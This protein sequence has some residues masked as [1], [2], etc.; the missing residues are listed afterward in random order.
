MKTRTGGTRAGETHRAPMRAWVPIAQSVLAVV[1]VFAFAASAAPSATA[2][3]RPAPQ[4]HSAKLTGFA[5]PARQ[6]RARPRVPGKSSR[7][8][9]RNWGGYITYLS[10]EL[11]DFDSVQATWVQP[12]VTCPKPRAW[13]VFWVGLDGWWNDTV[14]QGGTS[15]ECVGGVP[16]YESWWEMYPTNAITTVFAISPGDRISASVT[17]MTSTS[18]F[19]IAVSD[20]TSGQS[21]TMDEQCAAD[22]S[23][24]RNSADVIA[25]DVGK[26]GSGS[27]FPLADYKTMK[28][29]DSEVADVNNDSGPLADPNWLN[30]PVTEASG[31]TT[32]AKIS[33]L[34]M[35]GN[36]FAATWEHD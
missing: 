17:Y 26:S 24:A 23:C 30:A 6:T 34:N 19:V 14:E 1:T 22:L 21:F 28:F 5:G 15:A 20:L 9:S 2:V 29:T 12:V 33:A 36:G 10:S 35:K 4:A 8:T 27:F 16:E 13:T 18:T 3:S 7:F 31:A 11:T 32:Y 25:E